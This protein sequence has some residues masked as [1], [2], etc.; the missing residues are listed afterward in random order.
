MKR[1]KYIF[2]CMILSMLFLTGCGDDDEKIVEGTGIFY[3]NTDGTGLVKEKYKIKGAT[4]EEQIDRIL[5]EMQK[6]TDTI[7][8]VTPFPEGVEIEEWQLKNSMLSVY[9]NEKYNKLTASSE[10]LLRA[11]LV[12]TLVQLDDIR[13]IS[14][15]ADGKPIVDSK[16]EEIGYQNEDDFVQNIG[17]SL[18]SYQKGELTLYFANSD[19]TKLKSET[20]SVRYNSN[21]SKE[22]LIVEELIDG[23]VSAGLQA[24]FPTNTKILGVSVKDNNCYVNLDV[25]FLN[26][27]VAVDPKLTIYSLVN[28]IVEGGGATKVQILVNGET[29]V[30]YQES[31]DLSK[32]FSRDL[33]IIEEE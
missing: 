5:D 2:C 25:D 23:P 13:Y 19:G 8:F 9:F 31:I 4:V 10:V 24:T 28:S 11:A 29:N 30:K 27:P 21:M 26:T 1:M 18:H 14:F 20:V 17:S 15:Y 3:L 33:D 7:D 16:G 12:Q 32:S 6:E 22:K